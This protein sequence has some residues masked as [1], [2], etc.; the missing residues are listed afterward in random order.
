MRFYMKTLRFRVFI[1]NKILL[2]QKGPIVSKNIL[3][4]KLA[5]ET[6]ET[7]SQKPQYY[8]IWLSVHSVDFSFYF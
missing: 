6:R 3:V 4:P 5:G 7:G 1:N 2:K 8:K